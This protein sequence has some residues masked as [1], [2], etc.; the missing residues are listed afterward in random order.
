[1][2]D[3]RNRKAHDPRLNAMDYRDGLMIAFLALCP[4]RLGNLAQMRLGQHL[5]LENG[6]PRVRF[7]PGET[8]GGNSI[9]VAFPTELIADLHLYLDKIHPIL[10]TSPQCETA[11][12]PSLYK[13]PMKPSSIYKRIKQITKARLGYSITP[14]MFRD[15]AATFISEIA[16]E[17]AL[18]AASV[19]QHRS[20]KTTRKHYIHGQQHKA[21]HQYQAAIDELMRKTSK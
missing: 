9:D 10:A 16:P 15:A 1:M 11:L 18:M 4:I 21:C 14:H 13:T 5:V 7:E 3:W 12:W 6:L 2:A 17:R 19:L 8:K 20:F